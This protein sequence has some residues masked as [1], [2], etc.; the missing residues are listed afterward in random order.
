MSG[1][2][3]VEGLELLKS[4][5][6]L[7]MLQIQYPSRGLAGQ[8]E[9]FL[10]IWSIYRSWRLRHFQKSNGFV[11][12]CNYMNAGTLEVSRAKTSTK[13]P[14]FYFIWFLFESFLTRL[15]TQICLSE[16]SNFRYMPSKLHFWTKLG[17]FWWFWSFFKEKTPFWCWYGPKYLPKVQQSDWNWFAVSLEAVWDL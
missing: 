15:A 16:I 4:R 7:D 12:L 8:F 11:I 13:T 3:T 6:T 10:K 14:Y 17:H 2:R 5:Q 1:Y 9:H